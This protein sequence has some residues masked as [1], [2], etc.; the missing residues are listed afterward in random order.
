MVLEGLNH[1]C[2]AYLDDILIFSA[3]VEDHIA[4]INIVFDRLRQHKLKLKLKKCSFFK[5]TTKYLGFII[6]PAGISPDPDKAKIMK[7][8]PPPTSV[9]E[10]RGAIG[11]LSYYRRYIPNFSEIA[12]PIIDLTKRYA[13]FSW[14][15]KCQ[16]AFDY[17]KESLSIIP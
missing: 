9:K 16:R 5:Q 6:G 14:T 7:N 1:F 10:A 15:D 13:K 4:H 8:L 3:T 17:L 2:Q 12:T 11:M